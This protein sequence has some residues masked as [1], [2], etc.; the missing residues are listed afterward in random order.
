MIVGNNFG[1]SQSYIEPVLKY[2]G[3]DIPVFTLVSYVGHFSL[4]LPGVPC[5][6]WHI[7]KTNDP[8]LHTCNEEEYGIVLL[9]NANGTST[10]EL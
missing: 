2:I 4:S 3:S 5:L 1:T 10:Y 9:Y 8:F 7:Q 6:C